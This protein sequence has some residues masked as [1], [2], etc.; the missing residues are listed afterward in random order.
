MLIPHGDIDNTINE[1][2]CEINALPCKDNNPLRPNRGGITAMTHF[3]KLLG[4]KVP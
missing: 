1:P 3:H 2:Q 4:G